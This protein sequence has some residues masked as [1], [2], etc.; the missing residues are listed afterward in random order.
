MKAAG[1][2]TAALFLAA[3]PVAAHVGS[4]DVFFEGLAGPYQV[5]AAIRVPQVIPGVAE[6]ELRI[7][8]QGEREVRLTPMPLTGPG[9]R[10][11]PTPDRAQV[12]TADPTFYRGKLWMM[13]TGS[14]QVRVEI[15]GGQGR[16]ELRIPVPALARRTTEMDAALGSALFVL[17]L[18]LALGAVAIAGA[19]TGQGPVPPGEPIP[20]SRQRRAWVVMGVAAVLV[21]GAIWGGD[22]WW[23]A[24]AAGY[25]RIIFKPLAMKTALQGN[26]LAIDL[27]HTG[28]LQDKSFEDLIEDHGYLMH[29]FVVS[30]TMDRVWHLHPQLVAG[31]RFEQKLPSMPAG[32]YR[33]YGDIVHRNGL[34]E[35]LVA[36]VDWPA[37]TGE[38]LQGD[39]AA[40]ALSADYRMVMDSPAS[41]K[42]GR[43]E[44]LKFR[45]LDNAGQPA[46]DRET[47]LGMPAHAAV[48]RAD[49]QVFAH[50]HPSGTVPAAALALA[51]PQDAHAGHSMMADLPDEVTFPYGFPAPGEYRIF[52]QMKRAGVV[53]TGS[54][55]VQVQP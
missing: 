2:A 38:P 47:Y 3:F 50:L 27:E 9:A 5:F 19:A 46:R 26:R 11:A 32:Q 1:F 30:S 48:I 34:P 4:P 15:E 44:V 10:F 23:K 28:W 51:Q 37:I 31:G 18:F 7:P 35:T 6:V 14:W 8:G 43:L 13:S 12:S 49:G 16:G 22:R 29:L 54:F 39:D 42:A 45:L 52:V 36:E 40:S 41:A 53:E 25:S 24:E 21:G 20:A 55:T 17:L 33:L